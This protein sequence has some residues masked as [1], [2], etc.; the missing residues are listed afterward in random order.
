MDYD[1]IEIMKNHNQDEGDKKRNKKFEQI[2]TK[3]QKSALNSSRSTLVIF[4]LR[5]WLRR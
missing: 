1:I 4:G 2:D 3:I 5:M